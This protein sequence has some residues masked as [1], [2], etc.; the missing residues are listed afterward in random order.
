M[1]GTSPKECPVCDAVSPASTERCD[2]SYDFRTKKVETSRARPL[3]L[4]WLWAVPV[5]AL[6][7]LFALTALFYRQ[8]ETLSG[9]FQSH[10]PPAERIAQ[11]REMIAEEHWEN[12]THERDLEV[13]S[14]FHRQFGLAQP[15]AKR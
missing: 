3:D 5:A 9:Y 11:I 4:R 2:C 1:G 15:S 13:A 14:L 6:T 8:F 12:L 10:P 7:S